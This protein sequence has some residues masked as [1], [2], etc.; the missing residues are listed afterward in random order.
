[1]TEALLFVSDKL[2]GDESAHHLFDQESQN[3]LGTWLR[4]SRCSIIA[5]VTQ[6]DILVLTFA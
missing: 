4:G 2:A 3:K 6:K 1:M 5:E